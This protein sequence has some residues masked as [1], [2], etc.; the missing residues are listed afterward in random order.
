M[1]TTLKTDPVGRRCFTL[2]G[3][4]ANLVLIIDDDESVSELI[5]RDLGE[6]GYR[7]LIASSGEEGLRLAKQLLPS[8][9]ILDVVMPGIDGWSVLAALKTDDEMAEIPIIMA[10]MLDERDRGLQMGADEYVSKPFGRDCLVEL[11]QKHLGARSQAQI[12]VVEDDGP[13]RERLVETLRSEGWLVSEAANAGEA[14]ERLREATPDLVVLDILLPDRNG[15][16]VLSDIR[17]DRVWQSIPVIV[18]TAAEL[19][20]N[21]RRS[22]RGQVESILAKGLLGRDDLLRE[23]RA[24]LHPHQVHGPSIVMED[25]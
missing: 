6:Q 25:S 22:L 23:V 15:F 21:A 24:L 4:E 1:R 8:A 12:L 14:L 17:A 20:S 16:E 2:T 11:L 10:S 18:L 5:R 7:T 19:D 13:T 9:I 3:E